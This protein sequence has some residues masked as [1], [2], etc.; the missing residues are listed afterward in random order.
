MNTESLVYFVL[1]ALC[2]IQLIT[3]FR[4]DWLKGRVEDLEKKK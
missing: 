2:I 4:I 3:Q 1:L